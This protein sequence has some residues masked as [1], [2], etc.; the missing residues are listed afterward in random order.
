MA[1][2]RS[3]RTLKEYHRPDDKVMWTGNSGR[4]YQK[5]RKRDSQD[6]G[7]DHDAFTPH[8]MTQVDM[9]REAGYTGKGFK[10]AVID[11]GVST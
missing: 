10:I 3:I 2:V 5:S 11:T 1:G 9:L 4:A 6:G 7:R 8:L